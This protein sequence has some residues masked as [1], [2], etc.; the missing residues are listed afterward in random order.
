MLKWPDLVA[1][2]KDSMRSRS[3]SKLV[4]CGEDI[5][6]GEYKTIM[7]QT[8]KLY[9]WTPLSIPVHVIHGKK[10]GPV[11]CVTAAVHGDE[12]NG[13]EIIRQ[14][15]KK[16]LLKDISGTLIAIPIV[17]IF[18]F[19]NHDRYLMDR[20]DLNRSFPGQKTGSLASRL[21]HL[22]TSEVVSKSTHIIDLHTGSMHRTNLPQ[23][24]IDLETKE[25]KNLALSF[26][27]PVVLHSPLR[28]GSLRHYAKKKEIPF[29]LYEAGESM[30]FDQ[31]SIKTGI[32][33]ILNVMYYLKMIK[34]KQATQ[35]AQHKSIQSYD[36]Y[37]I[38]APHSGILSPTNKLGKT[39]EKGDL[40][41]KI[42]NPSDLVEHKLFSP[43]SGI[44]IGQ[45]NLPLVH[46]G[47]ALFHIACYKKLKNARTQ[48]QN[49]KDS[50][51]IPY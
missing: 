25:L 28:E 45:N 2:I 50:L 23:I 20:R 29:L 5:L 27:A 35:N 46:A 43:L 48:I 11:L 40:L 30:R 21:A 14:L 22:I 18:G 12:I 41:A 47:Q 13:I 36:S 9:D 51:L 10:P 6:P 24:R 42:G 33:G 49:F 15:L 39:V 32:K 8:P 26:N 16:K 34:N 17:N 7:L 4:I 1:D 38:R 44:I 37:W 19:L 3:Q 31:L